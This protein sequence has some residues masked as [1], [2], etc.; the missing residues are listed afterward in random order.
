[1]DFM[2]YPMCKDEYAMALKKKMAETTALVVSTTYCGY[3]NKAKSLLNRYSIPTTEI[4][5]D[6]LDPID[7]MELSNCIY[8]KN[9]RFVPLI[10]LKGEHVGGYGELLKLH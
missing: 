6:T 2:G 3:C 10:Y 8:G 9:Q 4:V 5:L 7:Q 1:M